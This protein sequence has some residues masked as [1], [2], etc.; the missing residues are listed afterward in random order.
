MGHLLRNAWG[1]ELPKSMCQLC[2]EGIH[3]HNH[4]NHGAQWPKTQRTITRAGAGEWS[5][6]QI[7]NSA[8]LTLTAGV[9]DSDSFAI[10]PATLGSGV[11]ERV[12]NLTLK[13]LALGVM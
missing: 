7:E 10:D 13:P 3:P 9:S 2:R 4:G 8:R 12:I 1:N 6:T 5:D 11:F